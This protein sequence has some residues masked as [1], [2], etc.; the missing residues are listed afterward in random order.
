MQ[1]GFILCLI[2]SEKK[3]GHFLVYILKIWFPLSYWYLSTTDISDVKLFL[4]LLEYNI[5]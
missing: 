5:F 3:L 4:I 2:L 1:D